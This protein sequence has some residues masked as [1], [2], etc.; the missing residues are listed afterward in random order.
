MFIRD[1]FLTSSAIG[2]YSVAVVMAQFLWYLSNALNT[3]LFPFLSSN[4]NKQ[5]ENIQFTIELT[6]IILALN[7][8]LI[9]LLVLF[10]KFLI[11]IF[12]LQD[13]ISAYEVFFMLTIGLLC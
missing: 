3:V 6:K 4:R 5:T 10:G 12:Y 11:F 1:S 9:T 2:I 7:L 13:F 8:I